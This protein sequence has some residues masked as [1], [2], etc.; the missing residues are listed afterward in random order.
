VKRKITNPFFV[1]CLLAL[2]VKIG[3]GIFPSFSSSLH[4]SSD[5][6]IF[7]SQETELASE[8]NL[9]EQNFE[10]VSLHTSKTLIA[11]QETQTAKSGSKFIILPPVKIYLQT[12]KLII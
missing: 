4:K 11:R 9:L 10:L 5:T 8:S 12:R 7:V 2:L 1:L 6:I 3:L